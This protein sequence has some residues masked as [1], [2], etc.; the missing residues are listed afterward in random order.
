MN[1]VRQIERDQLV[2]AAVQLRPRRHPLCRR[3]GAR[4]RQRLAGHAQE[5]PD[6]LVLGLEFGDQLG[7]EGP[8]PREDG[9]LLV[10]VVLLE[11][12][13]CMVE[14]IE[15]PRARVVI[16]VGRLHASSGIV[17]DGPDR[18][19]DGREQVHALHHG[20]PWFVSMLRGASRRV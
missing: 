19:V 13:Q 12:P 5:P 6:L 16:D 17:D 4:H 2:E 15:R 8:Q 9:A 3:G 11:Q 14:A 7:L 10:V 20:T 1:Q 18:L